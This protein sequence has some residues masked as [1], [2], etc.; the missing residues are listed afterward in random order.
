ML[1]ALVVG[2]ALVA[3]CQGGGDGARTYEVTIRQ[4]DSS[5]TI[6]VEI[7]RTLTE[8]QQGLM[9]R[10]ELAESAGMLFLHAEDVQFG[11]WMKNTYVALDIAYIAADGRV[12]EVRHGRPLDETVLQPAAPYRYVLETNDGWFER[13]GL[14]PGARMEIREGLPKADGR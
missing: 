9:Y 5:A 2:C 6:D 8:R 3:G 12:L 10:Q 4:G 14:G 11:F 13:H 1:A 7:A